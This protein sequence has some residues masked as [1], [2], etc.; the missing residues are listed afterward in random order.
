[1]PQVGDRVEIASKGGPRTGVVMALSGAMVSIRWD[2]G[3]DSTF[4]PGPG[5][6]S[7]IGNATATPRSGASASS[8]SV[9]PAKKAPAKKAPAKKAP[10]TKA[11][12]KKAPA[13]R[14]VR[15]AGARKAR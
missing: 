9:A 5:V 3:G 12:A 1:M 8:A 4:V 11:P 13:K 10:A 6:L 2:S 14:T 15:R 7:V